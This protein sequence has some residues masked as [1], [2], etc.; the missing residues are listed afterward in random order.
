MGK[1][2]CTILALAVLGACAVA[3]AAEAVNVA[4]ANKSATI[5]AIWQQRTEGKWVD[6]GPLGVSNPY[7]TRGALASVIDGMA[8]GEPY[9]GSDPNNSAEKRYCFEITLA[10]PSTLKQIVIF[11]LGAEGMSDA[12]RHT[13]SVWVQAL[14]DGGWADA[15]GTEVSP[16]PAEG[17]DFVRLSFD[18]NVAGNAS[19]VRVW[20]Y[21]RPTPIPRLENKIMGACPRVQ[22][23][24]VLG[25]PSGP[26][27]TL[28]GAITKKDDGSHEMNLNGLWLIRPQDAK[29]ETEKLPKGSWGSCLV[30]CSWKDEKAVTAGGGKVW[31]KPIAGA[32]RVWYARLVH[33]PA[34]WKGRRLTL[35][36]EG[37]TSAAEA[38]V[39]DKKVGVI[40]GPSGRVDVTEAVRFG[41]H[42]YIGILVC[43]GEKLYTFWGEAAAGAVPDGAGI[44]GKITLT[45]K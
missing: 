29:D 33:V 42:D 25:E 35:T 15:V 10:V 43:A 12:V 19:K 39:R 37:L 22:E 16:V 32:Q 44:K 34:S 7:F 11:T 4:D 9:F 21:G 3:G 13:K 2:L 5:T 8:A 24:M 31:K 30:P 18:V 27:K 1:T 17:K 6:K 40:E 36:V 14:I 41:R 38:Y 45:A 23:I 26:V 20:L 28:G